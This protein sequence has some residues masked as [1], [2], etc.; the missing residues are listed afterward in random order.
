M[1][2]R[3]SDTGRPS[4]STSHWQPLLTCTDLNAA[5]VATR[6]PSTC[7]L[8]HLLASPPPPQFAVWE[9]MQ[10]LPLHPSDDDKSTMMAMG[11][12]S[13]EGKGKGEGKGEGE[14]D[15]TVRERAG[16]LVTRTRH[17]QG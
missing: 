6:P 15:K 4:G 2:T 16:E 11:N 13:S 10:S 8:P 12:S 14:G 5:L 3:T 7:L 1:I 9:L 17:W